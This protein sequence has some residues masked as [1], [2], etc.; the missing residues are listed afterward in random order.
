MYQNDYLNEAVETD[1]YR[2]LA[3]FKTGFQMRKQ[4]RM[5]IA[6]WIFLDI[7]MKTEEHFVD[8]IK[9]R[10]NVSDNL[11]DEEDNM[12]ISFYWLDASDG[13]Q[14]INSNYRKIDIKLYDKT[15]NCVIKM[16][17]I[18]RGHNPRWRYPLLHIL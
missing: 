5:F 3:A 16:Q 11:Y 15:N 8:W 12:V 7:L 17:S 4:K 13:Y 10:V 2:T 6:H 14:G 18:I 1:V 9:Y